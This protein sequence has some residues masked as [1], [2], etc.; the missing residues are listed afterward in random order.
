MAHQAYC[1]RTPNSAINILHK[2]KDYIYLKILY[3]TGL[4]KIYPL[5]KGSSFISDGSQDNPEAQGQY[6]KYSSRSKSNRVSLVAQF[7]PKMII[8]YYR[9]YIVNWN[10]LCSL[11]VLMFYLNTSGNWKSE[12]KIILL[13]KTNFWDK[14]LFLS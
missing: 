2:K 14:C 3:F 13:D 8:F 6:R 7:S 5:T 12:W 1:A 11:Q 4:K 10:F 9:N